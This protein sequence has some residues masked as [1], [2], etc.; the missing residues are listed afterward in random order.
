MATLERVKATG[1]SKR[2]KPVDPDVLR[3]RVERTMAKL[4]RAVVKAVRDEVI[5]R[6]SGL[7]II[8]TLGEIDSA[9]N[10]AFPARRATGSAARL[11]FE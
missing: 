11:P 4:Q 9:L 1:T 8:V 3:G 2:K 6:S 10:A 7:Q 5:A